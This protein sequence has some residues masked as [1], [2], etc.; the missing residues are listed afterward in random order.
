VIKEL[1]KHIQFYFLVL[2]LV[3]GTVGGFSKPVKAETNEQKINLVETLKLSPTI[4]I[5]AGETPQISQAENEQA[6]EPEVL[7]G[8]VLVTGERADLEA[9]L[10]D[11]VYRTIETRPGRTTTRSQLQRDVNAIY[12]TGDFA[13]VRVIPEDTPLGVRITFVVQENPIFQKLEVEATPTDDKGSVVPA[14]EIEK[15]FAPSYGKRL[16]LRN[17]QEDIKTLKEWYTNNGYDLAQIVG[18]PRISDDGVVTLIVAE[19]AIED[20][21]VRYFD[22]ENETVKGRTRPFIITREVQL[23]PGDI[24]NA[25]TARADLQRVFGLGIFEDVRLSFAPGEDPRKVIVNIDVQESSTRAITAGGGVSS[26][27]GLFGSVSFL[28]TNIGG[29]NQTFKFDF[30]GGERLLVFDAS[31]TDPWIG[32][33]PYR[34]S[35]TIN[36]FRRRSI[37][38][39]YSGD[40]PDLLT[41]NDRPL[42]LSPQILQNSTPEELQLRQNINTRGSRA[43]VLRTGA[44]INFFRPFATDPFTKPVWKTSAGFQYQRVAIINSDG[45]VTPL[46]APFV[47]VDNV[48]QPVVPQIKLAA[49]E[50]GKDDLFVFRIGASRDL[51]DNPLNATKGSFLSFSSDQTVP[52]GSG[53]I[54]FNRLRANYS[55]YIP[56]KL[57]RFNDGPQAFAFNLQGGTIIGD[58]PPYEGF[59]IGGSNSVRGYGEGAIGSG[60]SYFQATAEYRFPIVDISSFAVGGVLFF[61]YGTNFGSQVPGDITRIRNLPGDGYGY[62][63]GVRVNSPVGPIRVDYGFNDRGDNEFTFGIGQRF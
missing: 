27:S 20:I 17:L 31:F 23:K 40:G 33:D 60:R 53:N 4:Q 41:F 11:L 10:I 37:S 1:N 28:A 62:G 29:N 21:Q 25:T 39:I 12:A 49:S 35:Y 9:E 46:S 63:V 5:L 45:E 51:R 24:F 50:S 36:A 52:I 8:E 34:T 44:G 47:L 61:D 55:F 2:A 13:N 16:N 7:V 15:I 32:G 22:E 18:A 14:A 6:P 57:V 19:G 30:Q 48:L 58:L 54:L 56:V 38:L 3:G 42:E 59:T 26:D 43:R